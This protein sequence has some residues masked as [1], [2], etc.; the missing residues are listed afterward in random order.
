MVKL[1][2]SLFAIVLLAGCSLFGDNGV[3]SAPYTLLK[4]D[5]SANIEVRNYDSLVL[6]STDMA[7]DGRN[8]AFRKLFRYIDGENEAAA[9]IAMTAPVMMNNSSKGEKIAMTAPVLMNNQPGA[10][11]MSFV[12]PKDFTLQTTPKPI[13]PDVMVTEVKDYKVAAIQFSGTLSKSNVA[14]Q[15][16]LLRAWITANGYTAKGEPVEAGYNGPLTLPMLR[17]NE[18]LIE[19]H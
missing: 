12:M 16:A 11:M 5:E 1:L 3:E 18:V 14:K 19:I 2:L 10:S 4:A 7:G 9:N 6:V 17:R 8:S 15:T 13:N